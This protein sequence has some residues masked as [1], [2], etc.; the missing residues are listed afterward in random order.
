MKYESPNYE[1]RS[2]KKNFGS[3][4]VQSSE[5]SEDGFDELVV[6]LAENQSVHFEVMNENCLW[7]NIAGCIFNLTRQHG[8][9]VLGFYETLDGAALLVDKTAT[10]ILGHIQATR[11]DAVRVKRGLAALRKRQIAYER[12]RSA[13]ET[14][15]TKKAKDKT[16]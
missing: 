1:S 14:K 7:M 11:K 13:R 3:W 5:W 6:R 9:W 4:R 2:P 8:V 16:R 15:E 10:K 12:R